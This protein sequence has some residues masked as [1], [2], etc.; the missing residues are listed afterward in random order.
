VTDAQIITEVTAFLGTWRTMSLATVDA[1]GHAHAA[2]IQFVPD[3]ALNLYFV[4][5]LASAHSQ[6]IVLDP[7][8][9]AT[10]YAHTDEH[11]Q[12]HGVQLHGR[13]A[14]VSDEAEKAKAWDLYVDRFDFIQ[15]NAMFEKH[16]RSEP[17]FKVTPTWL[18]WIDNRRSFGFKMEITLS[19]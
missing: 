15:G 17:F 13:C 6:H 2:N 14:Q 16:L 19:A 12:I 7:I 11:T 8:V 18:R 5:G 9:A 3:D 4:S 10:I 1:Q